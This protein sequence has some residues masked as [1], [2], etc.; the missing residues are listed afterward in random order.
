MLPL[1]SVAWDSV[2]VC[3]LGRGERALLSLQAVELGKQCLWR[4]ETKASRQQRMLLNPSSHTYT[5]IIHDL[6]A[7]QQSMLRGNGEKTIVH[8]TKQMLSAPI[9]T[10]F[11][12]CHHSL[13]CRVFTDWKKIVRKKGRSIP[14]CVGHVSAVGDE[15]WGQEGHQRETPSSY[16]DLFK[17][18][19]L[20]LAYN[21]AFRP[22]PLPRPAQLPPAQGLTNVLSTNRTSQDFHST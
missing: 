19:P 22:Q 18:F 5:G 3:M 2:C 8:L 13:K 12:S 6:S 10:S 16:A 17:S 1:V 9:L 4:P 20:C 15:E 14:V 11:T 21:L 7:S